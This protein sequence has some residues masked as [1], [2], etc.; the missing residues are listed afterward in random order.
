MRISDWSSDVC[1]SDLPAFGRVFTDHMILLRWSAER[2]WHDW[3][4]EQ[5]RALDLDPATLSLHYA[6][7]I[8]E[9]LKAYRLP[10][11][12]A[13][14]FR[15]DANARRF[16]ASAERMAMPLLPEELFTDSVRALVRTDRAWI[17][18]AEGDR[19]STRLNSRH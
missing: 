19:K 6:L 2:G 7:E 15:P 10:D 8:F 12:G 9:G 17:P 4:L 1:S 3:T 5:R 16:R 18:T 13:A 14:L 11:G